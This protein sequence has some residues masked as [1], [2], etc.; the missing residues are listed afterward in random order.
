MRHPPIPLALLAVALAWPAAAQQPPGPEPLAVGTRAPNF[1]LVS[2][3]RGGV[4][5]EVSLEDFHGQTVV[6]AF[7]PRARTGG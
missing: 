1:T 6:L 7:F 3:T 2:A 4:Q 5:G